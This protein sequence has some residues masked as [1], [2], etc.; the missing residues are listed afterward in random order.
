MC[1]DVNLP[2]TIWRFLLSHPSEP[3]GCVPAKRTKWRF[4]V[5]RLSEP[6]GDSWGLAIVNPIFQRRFPVSR[7]FI[8]PALPDVCVCVKQLYGCK[9]SMSHLAI[10]VVSPQWTSPQWTKFRSLMSRHREPNT[11]AGGHIPCPTKL[12]IREGSIHWPSMC[13][14][15]F[16]LWRGL[17]ICQ[18]LLWSLYFYV[19]GLCA[20]DSCDL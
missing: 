6:K 14:G 8:R 5:S 17:F 10:L 3:N 9:T 13:T 18:R 12:C 7:F 1:I 15:L 16:I 2:W 20:K 11:Y 19:V 4:L